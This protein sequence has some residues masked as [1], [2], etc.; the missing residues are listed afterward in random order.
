MFCVTALADMVK[1]MGW[2][3]NPGNRYRSQKMAPTTAAPKPRKLT[4][5]QSVPKVPCWMRFAVRRQMPRAPSFDPLKL[6]TPK[7]QGN[8]L[9]FGDTKATSDLADA[10]VKSNG[11]VATLF[12]SDATGAMLDFEFGGSDHL[13]EANYY[14]RTTSMSLEEVLVGVGT[15]SVASVTVTS[16]TEITVDGSTSDFDFTLIYALDGLGMLVNQAVIGFKI[17]TDV[18][19]DAAVM[20]EA[21]EE[22]LEI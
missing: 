4:R 19:A 1:P 14:Y 2:M 13:Y 17:W 22:Y 10:V 3:G 16:P 8:D 21:L 5:I 15:S 11:G 9:Y 20:R 6:G 12:V 7:L 18:D